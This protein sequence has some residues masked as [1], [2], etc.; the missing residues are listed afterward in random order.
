[1]IEIPLTR[2]CVIYA[3]WNNLDDN[4]Y[5]GS[6]K[7]FRHRTLT[8]LRLLKSNKHH[9]KHLQNAWNKYGEDNF[10]LLVLKKSNV[11]NLLLDEQWCLDILQPVYNICKI[12]GNTSG[13][14]WTNERRIKQLKYLQNKSVEHIENLKKSL[15]NNENFIKN[16]I[17]KCKI[18]I[19]NNKK[20][21]IITD[22][23][24]NILYEFSSIKEASVKLNINKSNIQSRLNKIV[25]SPYKNKLIFKYK[26]E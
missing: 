11:K 26:N 20:P 13:V 25:K 7:D 4:F 3:I 21:I 14:K 9:C 6:T 22:L 16:S 23:E 19:E 8:H 17:E 18:M 5:I 15:K 12:A 2:D 10:E 24:N 1:M